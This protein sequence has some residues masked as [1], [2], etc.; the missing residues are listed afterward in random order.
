MR[1]LLAAMTAVLAASGPALS[2]VSQP[3]NP[4]GDINDFSGDTNTLPSVIT[5]VASATGGDVIEARFARRNGVG[6]YDVL[7]SKGGQLDFIRLQGSGGQVQ[8]IDLS[9]RPKWM[10]NWAQRADVRIATNAKVPLETAV[11]TAEQHEGGPAV[12]AGIA[13]GAANN[14]TD[15]HAYN[16]L[17]ALRGGGTRRVAIDSATGLVISDPGALPSWP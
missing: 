6:G 11:R 8:T 15:V 17:I 10:L 1:V 5:N 14:E 4:L 2:Q 3:S 16:V 12:A 9:S 7:I 13:R